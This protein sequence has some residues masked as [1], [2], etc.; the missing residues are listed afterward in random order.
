MNTAPNDYRHVEIYVG[1][2]RIHAVEAGS[3]P[4]VLLIHGFPESWHSWKHQIAAISEAGYH[5]VAPDMRGYGRSSK[6]T[7]VDDYRVTALVNDLVGLVDHY[8]EGPAVVIG[9]DWGAMVAW[10]AAWTRPDTFRAV[11]ALSVPF[12]GRGLLP[13]AGVSTYGELP[14]KEAHRRIAGSEDRLFYQEYWQIPGALETEF[15]ADPRG[16][17]TE[18]YYSFSG[19]PYPEDFEMPDPHTAT[20]EQVAEIVKNSGVS[21][22]QGA[23]FRDGFVRPDVLPAWLAADID[24]YV[25]EFQRTGLVGPLNWYRCMDLNW[26][27]LAAYE[28]RKITQPAIFLSGELDPATLWGAESIQR[29]NEMVPGMTEVVLLPGCGHWLTREKPNE[30]SEAL[31]QF[32]HTIDNK[33]ASSANTRK[34][35]A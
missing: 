8:N 4:L 12:G 5:V 16:F 35:T 19:E 33:V 20:P 11:G 34:V 30:T 15:E 25:E 31:V 21:L 10:T 18:L 22:P 27:L 28:G 2:Q 13:I 17:L 26:E 3:G 6:P 7:R 29:F 23:K 24:F 32:L 1:D 9:H 14:P